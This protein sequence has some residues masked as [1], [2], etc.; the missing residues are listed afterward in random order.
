MAER[1][2]ME[3]IG[4]KAFLADLLP[5]L[6]PH[7]TFLN[8]FGDDASAI[9]IGGDRAVL[10]KIDRAAAPVAARRGWTDYRMWGRLAVTS[11][12]SDLLAGGGA[13]LAVMIALI[14]PRD[15]PASAAVEAIEGCAQECAANDIAFAGGDTKEGRSAELVGSAIG[16]VETGRIL[17]RRAAK[18]GDLIVLAGPL[19]G[20]LGAYLQIVES[21][22]AD[23]AVGDGA[24]DRWLD[25]ISHP[26][27]RWAEGA[28]IRDAGVATGAMDTSDGLYEAV[29]TLAGPHGADIRLSELP[30]HEF[31]LACAAKL[32]IP[33]INLALG[34]GDWNIV[35][36]IDAQ[37]WERLGDLPKTLQV[38]V[39]GA[40]SER[41]GLRWHD[42]A[43]GVFR[44]EQIVNQHF[45]S[46]QEDEGDMI[47][48]LRTE[49]MLRPLDDA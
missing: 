41:P 13:P 3:Q 6:A 40:V 16:L 42:D 4:E 9:S 27:A 24:D 38:Q 15:W 25:Y 43:S 45:K 48:R 37:R 34:V 39:I 17:T 1:Q 2:T 7:P 14:L 32:D 29:A 35:Y 21:L 11:N 23:G 5:R 30:Y 28:F 33:P 44:C 10:F 8:G 49:R 47:R 46:R 19:G 22:D 36:T 20:F 31:A 26:R 18:P 12:C